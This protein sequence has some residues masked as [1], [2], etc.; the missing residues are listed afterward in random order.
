MSKFKWP[1]KIDEHTLYEGDERGM[2]AFYFQE[3]GFGFGQAIEIEEV[4]LKED[5]FPEAKNQSIVQVQILSGNSWGQTKEG[6]PRTT[7]EPYTMHWLICRTEYYPNMQRALDA[8]T[9]KMEVPK[10][11]RKPRPIPDMTEDEITEHF[12]LPKEVLFKKEND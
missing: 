4:S 9:G 12:G 3:S 1:E 11:K 6:K 8:L 10:G 5:E 2:K 7:K